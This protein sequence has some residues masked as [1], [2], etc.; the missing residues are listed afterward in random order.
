MSDIESP[1]LAQRVVRRMLEGDTATAMLGM[2]VESV[3]SGRAVVAMTVRGDM[4]NGH[5]S[6]HGGLIFSLADSAFAFAC[7]SGN[8]RTVA[9]GCQIDFVKATRLGD[10]L[11]AEAVERNAGSRLG[12][13]DITVSNQHGELVA[14]FRGKSCRIGG[15]VIDPDEPAA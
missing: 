4:L 11:R 3:A 8:Q 12:V 5:A 1:T 15:H 7:N 14:L 6:C 13:Y 2:E 9:A 10:R